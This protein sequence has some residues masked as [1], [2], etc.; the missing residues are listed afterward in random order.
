MLVLL[1]MR[2]LHLGQPEVASWAWWLTRP[3]LFTVLA[4]V[5]AVFVVVFVR[6]DR[7]PRTASTVAADPRRWVDPVAAVSGFVIFLGILMVSVVGVDVLGARSVFFLVADVTP[8][9]GFAVLATG[10][11]MLAATRSLD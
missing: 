9:I 11:A 1:A 8:A 10:L 6:F 7:G 5:T 4:V 2:G 3:V